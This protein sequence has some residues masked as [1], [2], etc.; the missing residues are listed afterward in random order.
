MLVKHKGD[1]YFTVKCVVAECM[2]TTKTWTAYRQ[3]CKHKHNL[4]MNRNMLAVLQD[5]FYG[6]D[7]YNGDDGQPFPRDNTYFNDQMI[8]A[9]CILP[10]E[11]AHKVSCTALDSIVSSTETM[12]CEMFAVYDWCR[13]VNFRE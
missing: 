3:H 12:M 10:L 2:Y 1:A 9:K 7:N 4:Y 5:E 13:F 8:T 6:N 11:A